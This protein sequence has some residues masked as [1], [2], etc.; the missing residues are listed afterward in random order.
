MAIP[1]S[2]GNATDEATVQDIFRQYAKPASPTGRK[3]KQKKKN[4][5]RS[6][7]EEENQKDDDDP[8]KPDLILIGDV[9][10]QQR[11][12]APSHFDILTSTVL[13][14]VGPQTVVLFGTRRRMPASNDLWYML[15]EVLDEVLIVSAEEVD[16]DMFA[17]FPKHGISIHVFR[18][19]ET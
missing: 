10:Y 11:P 8:S 14:M 4:A 16:P 13:N 18:K 9:A 2:W 1:L 5:T 7:V 15:A 17:A 19:K 3:K 6:G 12:G